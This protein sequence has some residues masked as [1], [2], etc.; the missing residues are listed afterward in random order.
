MIVLCPELQTK[1]D[2]LWSKIVTNIH[3][4]NP[5]CSQI[6]LDEMCVSWLETVVT[7]LL[8]GHV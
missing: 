8:D 1:L 4:R 3:E 6:D 7:P 2:R 5:G